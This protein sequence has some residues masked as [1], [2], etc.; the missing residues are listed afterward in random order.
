MGT[1]KKRGDI[2]PGIKDDVAL[3]LSRSL[4]TW[5]KG[6]WLRTKELA[7]YLGTTEGNIRNMVYRGQL[8]PRCFNR[9]YYFSVLEVDKLIEASGIGGPNG[10]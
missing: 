5:Q 10:Y 8:V 6:K 7:R 9:R 3:K 2:W 4:T 1:N